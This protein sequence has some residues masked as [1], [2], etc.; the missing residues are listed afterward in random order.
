MPKV[1]VVSQ[2]DLDEVLDSVTQLDIRELYSD[3]LQKP[4]FCCGEGSCT[5]HRPV[6]SKG[7]VLSTKNSVF[8]TERSIVRRI[9]DVVER[10]RNVI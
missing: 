8:H 3:Q 9:I 6:A 2:I 1:Q 5:L 10:K 7:L 4:S